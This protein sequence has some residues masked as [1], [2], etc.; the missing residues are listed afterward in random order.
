M[1]R[2]KYDEL[3]K[4]LR[5]NINN[6]TFKHG[7]RIPTE[8]ELALQ[9]NVSR[10]TVRKAISRLEEESLLKR[11]QG[12]GTYVNLPDIREI[13]SLRKDSHTIGIMMNDINSYIFSYIVKGIKETL[14]RYGYTTSVHFTANKISLERNILESF[15]AGDYAGLII[16]PTKAALPLLNYDLYQKIST[17]IPT[18]TIHAK[19]PQLPISSVTMAD[20]KGAYMLTKYLL[21]NGHSN[22]AIFL[23]SDEQTGTNRY[24]GYCKAYQ[25]A[26]LP[27]NDDNI[28]WLYSGI[29]PSY[30][31]IFLDNTAR[32]KI[33]E[34]TAIIC[35]DDR[36]ALQLKHYLAKQN[37]NNDVIVCGFDNSD[38][39]QKNGF[40]SV[41]HMQEKFGE[42]AALRLIE[43]M[44]APGSDVSLEITPS[45]TVR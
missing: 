33:F 20:E 38:I 4:W 5:N 7:D 30:F 31:E 2:F 17:S 12:S 32:E 3:A 9:F 43:L 24:V 27:I 11:V 15:I 29:T 6:G 13:S 8:N 40:T 36:L 42:Y 35:H 1:I 23:K 45:L 19:I 26:G 14:S 28:F 41:S 10:D 22:I 37:I 39:A 44:K 16:E 18:V 34:N 25:D 21:D